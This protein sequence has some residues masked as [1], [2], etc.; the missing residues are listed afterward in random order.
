METKIDKSAV[1]Q[2]LLNRFGKLDELTLTAVIIMLNNRINLPDSAY[3]TMSNTAWIKHFR[4]ELL[5]YLDLKE[6]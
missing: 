3:T 2:S 5:E 4:K 6:E 1:T